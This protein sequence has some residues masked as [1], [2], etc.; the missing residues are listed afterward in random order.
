MV[1]EI[2][3]FIRIFDIIMRTYGVTRLLGNACLYLCTSHATK[4]TINFAVTTD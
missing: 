2:R 1:S 3:D 4:G